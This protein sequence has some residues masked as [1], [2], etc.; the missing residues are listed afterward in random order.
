MPQEPSD[1]DGDGAM[2][3]LV[4]DRYM[5]KVVWYRNTNGQGNFVQQQMLTTDIEYTCDAITAD[6]DGDGDLDIVVASRKLEGIE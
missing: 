5:D 3:I 1:I 6:L 4:A 2:D